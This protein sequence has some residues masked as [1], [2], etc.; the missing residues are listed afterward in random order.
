M[1]SEHIKGTNW[2][3]WQL[4]RQTTKVKK[5]FTLRTPS[6]DARIYF[7]TFGPIF[8]LSARNLFGKV[9]YVWR[10]Q[11][12]FDLKMETKRF[13]N[14]PE[15]HRGFGVAFLLVSKLSSESSFKI[16]ISDLFSYYKWQDDLLPGVLACIAPV[17]GT[18][19][20]D[21]HKENWILTRHLY[22]NTQEL[23]TR[24]SFIYK[25]LL[26]LNTKKDCMTALF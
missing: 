24:I 14:N 20:L 23:F 19:K 6:G 2:T 3:D 13:V 4:C 10:I 17:K 12:T 22:R 11:F 16:L 26:N 5:N 21:F 8:Q 9:E 25:S 1:K 15:K 7:V 18:S